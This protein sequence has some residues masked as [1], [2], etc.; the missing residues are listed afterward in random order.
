MDLM[1]RRRTMM[2]LGSAPAGGPVT[3]AS[4]TFTGSGSYTLTLP[5]GTK[6]AQTDFVMEIWADPD[7]EFTYDSNYK[8]ARLTCSCPSEFLRFDLSTEG[9]K[10]PTSV[11]TYDVNNSGTITS[12]SLAFMAQHVCTIRSNDVYS[13][14]FGAQRTRI[15]RNAEGFK[16]Y[17]NTS[18]SAYKFV[19]GVTYHWKL[20]YYG[21]NPGS[22]II[23]I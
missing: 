16:F 9:E 12:K 1:A 17:F 19:S 21:A 8:V 4:G 5:I 6:A 18:N 13:Q 20:L 3:V 10:A 22:D 2:V 14:D 15:I 11:L 7:T 23:T